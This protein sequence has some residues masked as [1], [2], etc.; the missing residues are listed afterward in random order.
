VTLLSEAGCTLQQIAT[1]SGHS[2]RTVS[3]IVE[4]YLAR[5][6]ALAEQAI[7]NLENSPRTA[8]A[9]RQTG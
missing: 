2:L 3:A 9:N 8:F 4:R 5:T 1:I 6:A 7:V